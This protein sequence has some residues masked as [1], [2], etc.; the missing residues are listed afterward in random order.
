M[1][2][3]EA[4]Q[5]GKQSSALA[6]TTAPPP[7]SISVF[8]GG[9]AEF[10]SAQRMAA[11]LCSST[12]VPETYRGQNNLGNCLVAL[13]LANRMGV[14]PL[15]IMQNMDAI[16]GRPAFRS[17]FLI[18][19][20]NGCGRFTTIEFHF[21]DEA[22]PTSCYAAANSIATGA[23]LVGQ[24]ITIAMAKTEGWWDRKGSKWPNMTG[25]MLSYRAASFW[26]RI[27]APELTVGFRTA[28]EVIDVESVVVTEVE[29]VAAAAPVPEPEP[30]P[31]KATSKAKPK[32]APDPDAAADTQESTFQSTSNDSQIRSSAPAADESSTDADPVPPAPATAP[33]AAEPIDVVPLSDFAQ[34]GME[35]IVQQCQLTGLDEF[36][37]QVEGFIAAGSVTQGEGDRLMAGISTRAGYLSKAI[38]PFEATAAIKKIEATEGLE[39]RFREAFSIP[40]SAALSDV[41][42]ERQ[43]VETVKVLLAAGGA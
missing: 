21:D 29:P 23:R 8:T 10:E 9:I 42:A 43:H 25:Q 19:M 3:T 11:A 33:Q 6:K 17:S 32:P 36:R 27:H 5:W 15:A 13:D 41:V 18:A 30:A 31:A 40:D 22:N 7:S 38:T 12:M 28:E 14:S 24:K 34:Q 4:P 1:T 16:H 37:R 20:I 39:Q 26:Q 2:T 35:M